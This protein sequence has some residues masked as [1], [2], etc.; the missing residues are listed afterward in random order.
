VL[1]PV[2]W[3]A[4]FPAAK[5]A[6]EDLSTL[7]LITWTRGLGLVTLLV[8]LPWMLWSQDVHGRNLGALIAPGG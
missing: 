8:V 1:T 3:G 2:L 6:P 7:A 5:L 4:T